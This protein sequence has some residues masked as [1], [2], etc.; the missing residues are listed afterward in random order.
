MLG[1]D[2]TKD[3]HV[4]DGERAKNTPERAGSSKN[5]IE[6]GPNE[7]G[8]RRNREPDRLGTIRCG[9]VACK[10]A[11]G[12]DDRPTPSS[13]RPLPVTH[14]GRRHPFGLRAT[15]F[16]T[17]S[18]T[19]S[20]DLPPRKPAPVCRNCRGRSRSDA[21]REPFRTGFTGAGSVCSVSSCRLL[22][23]P[24]LVGWAG[25]PV[26]LSGLGMRK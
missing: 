12:T 24:I 2:T 3:A 26:W 14:L 17:P 5:M 15:V 9:P 16:P 1:A 4:D 23:L 25:Q 21:L 8:F 22:Y 7:L 10:G 20:R 18:S 11:C 19:F 6:I 13:V